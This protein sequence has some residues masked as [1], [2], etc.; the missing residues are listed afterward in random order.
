MELRLETFN[1]VTPLVAVRAHEG[2]CG[3]LAAYADD[4]VT[5]SAWNPA[6]RSTL[7]L[8]VPQLADTLGRA[9]IVLWS[10]ELWEAAISGGGLFA[11]TVVGAEM[12]PRVL[13]QWYLSSPPI[14]DSEPAM[15]AMGLDRPCLLASILAIPVRGTA[16][17]EDAVGRGDPEEIARTLLA[18]RDALYGVTFVLVFQPSA[19]GRRAAEI[20]ADLLPHLRP[21][22]PLWVGETI[23]AGSLRTDL[24]AALEFLK[25]ECVATERARLP[26]AERRQRARRGERA[27]E[28]IRVVLRRARAERSGGEKRQVDWQSR[29][30]VSE[31]WRRQYYPSTGEHRPKF[32]AEHVK[33]PEGKPIR[34]R[35]GRVFVVSR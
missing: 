2:L 32:I 35:R 13:Q 14:F 29:W 6:A 3:I 1:E 15:R 7:H 5:A 24:V 16:G 28:V 22:E 34:P 19:A 10:N 12:V 9:E 18:T 23:Q 8:I 31:H 4:V 27:P 21:L 26:R 11:G 33:G 17:L 20:D 25:Q 30:I